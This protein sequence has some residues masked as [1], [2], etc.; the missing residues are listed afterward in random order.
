MAAMAAGDR[1]ATFTLYSEYGSA[2]AGAVRRQLAHRGVHELSRGEVDGLV[3]DMCLELY[4]L[5]PSWHADSGAL[6]WV[7]AG[8]R[9]GNIVDRWL[10]QY[11]KPLDDSVLENLDASLAKRPPPVIVFSQPSDDDT[12]AVFERMTRDD[13]L[14]RLLQEALHASG[15]CTR[16]QQLLLEVSLQRSLGD[17]S[18]AVTVA[19]MYGMSTASVRQQVK[20][21]RDRVRRLACAEPRYAV[22]ADLA[23]LAA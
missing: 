19:T 3:M 10:G 12:G 16:D 2:I 1:A 21:A 4:D 11:T 23:V 8:Q 5:A 7:W 20:R 14:C 22:L 9:I 17:R 15:T 6:P 18:P 13:G